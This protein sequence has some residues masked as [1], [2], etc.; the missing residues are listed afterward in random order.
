LLFILYSKLFTN[1]LEKRIK[2]LN[3]PNLNV[4][5][6]SLIYKYISVKIRNINKNKEKYRTTDLI[7]TKKDLLFLEYINKKFELL[8][9]ISIRNLT[10]LAICKNKL[11]CLVLYDNKI[12]C[13][14]IE[15][16]TESAYSVFT[17][18]DDLFHNSPDYFKNE[19]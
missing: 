19:G 18:I 11:N 7:I 15:I 10:K 6:K 13:D 12:V 17:L 14:G 9:F 16:R 1:F 3:I 8:F 5:D 2:E 4:S